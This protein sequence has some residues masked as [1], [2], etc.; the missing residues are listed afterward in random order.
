MYKSKLNGR[1]SAKYMSRAE[2]NAGTYRTRGMNQGCL[3][4]SC[5]AWAGSILYEVSNNGKA[6]MYEYIW[7]SRDN[8]SEGFFIGMQLGLNS[9]NV[10]WA[11]ILSSL[12]FLWK[13][14]ED[15]EFYLYYTTTYCI[16]AMFSS[17][18]L[19]IVCIL[20]LFLITKRLSDMKRNRT[21]SLSWGFSSQ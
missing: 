19:Y 16:Y 5:M 12:N 4:A 17:F 3:Y 9:E 13:Q 2:K 7:N 20:F 6:Q 8:R 15:T 18:V 11:S 1:E 21:A 14:R 10:D